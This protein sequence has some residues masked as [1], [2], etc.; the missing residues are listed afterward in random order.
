M[1]CQQPDQCLETVSFKV[2][3]QGKKRFQQYYFIRM[4]Y[5]SVSDTGISTRKKEIRVLPSGV[6]ATTIRLL[7]QMLLPMSYRRHSAY[8]LLGF[9]CRCVAFAQ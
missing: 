2:L 3:L 6:E 7:V 4:M 1:N 5:Y 9:E 8:I